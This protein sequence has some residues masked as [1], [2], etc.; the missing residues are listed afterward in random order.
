[1]RKK[2][3]AVAERHTS[4]SDLSLPQK[5]Q[6]IWDY[7]KLPIFAGLFA[8]FFILSLLFHHLGKKEAVLHL[9]AVNIVTGETLTEKLTD[10]FLSYCNGSPDQQEVLYYTGLY[11]TT[12]E[13][14]E[15]Y[16]YNYAS[17]VKILAAIDDERLDVVLM[18]QEAFDAF[19][20][21]GYLYDLSKLDGLSEQCRLAVN[22]EI[23]EDNAKE[24]VYDSSV[25]YQSTVLEY[26]MGIDAGCFPCFAEAGFSE[27]VYLGVI[28]NTQRLDTVK[29][30]LTY[31]EI[32]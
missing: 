1:M 26:P 18:N 13:S 28:A 19:A 2:R 23:V 6:Y 14:S 17:Q 31:L 8:A 21:N 5:A 24:V 16:A 12:D 15:Y 10:G 32:A 9:G 7:Y 27:P 3:P 20:Q 11:L 25:A 22:K 30:F 4:W 29:Q